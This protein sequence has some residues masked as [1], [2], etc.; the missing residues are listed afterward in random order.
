MIKNNLL[1]GQQLITKNVQRSTGKQEQ[2]NKKNATL[3]QN[4]LSTCLYFSTSFPELSSPRRRKALGTRLFISLWFQI[5]LT[6]A[7][8]QMERE[9]KQTKTSPK[10][11]QTND[12]RASDILREKVATLKSRRKAY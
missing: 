1:R 3:R 12:L 6:P 11:E 4:V 8:T 9:K 5:R 2:N 10:R 7:V